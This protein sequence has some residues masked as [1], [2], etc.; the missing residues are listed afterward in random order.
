MPNEISRLK[1]NQV[2][3]FDEFK[4]NILE[5]GSDANFSNRL[6]NLYDNAPRLIRIL[7]NFDPTG[8]ASAL[9]QLISDEKTEKEQNN[10]LRMLYDLAVKIWKVEGTELPSLSAEKFKFLYFVYIKSETDVYVR[11]LADEIQNLLTL[12]QLR[13]IS[14]GEYLN[15]NELIDFSNWVQGIKI[16]HKGIVRVEADLLGNNEMPDYVSLDEIKKMEERIRLR[17]HLLKHLYREAKEDTFKKISHADLAKKAGLEHHRTISQ[18]LPYMIVEG[19]VKS[20]TVDSISITEEGID[21]VKTLL[22]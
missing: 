20:R 11:V 13:I 17:F 22:I 7:H 14:I 19:W 16:M 3:S 5:Q 2:P 15:R 12:P 4:K 18:L 9:D 6:E 8:T 21:R 10:I 1:P